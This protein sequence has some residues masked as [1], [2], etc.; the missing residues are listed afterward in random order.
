MCPSDFSSTISLTSNQSKEQGQAGQPSQAKEDHGL[1]RQQH[2]SPIS[3]ALEGPGSKRRTKCRSSPT[4]F[5]EASKTPLKVSN[6][7]YCVVFKVTQVE[8]RGGSKHGISLEGGKILGKVPVSCPDGRIG[9]E[10]LRSTLHGSQSVLRVKLERPELDHCGL[11]QLNNHGS[12]WHGLLDDQLPLQTGELHF[13]DYF[14]EC[15]VYFH[16]IFLQFYTILYC[17]KLFPP[18]RSAESLRTASRAS[19]IPVH[20]GKGRRLVPR[21]C[22]PRPWLGTLAR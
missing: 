6:N 14:R 15:T 3:A 7:L 13:H 9:L 17:A 11:N 12:G 18:Q 4:L 8:I 19:H 10:R 22:S 2:L 20:L 21:A 16:S 5:D 1:E